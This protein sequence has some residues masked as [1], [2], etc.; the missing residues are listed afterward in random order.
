M[1]KIIKSV[2]NPVQPS[3]DIKV[4]TV[5]ERIIELIRIKHLA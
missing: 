5:I 2:I 1:E 4:K 3:V